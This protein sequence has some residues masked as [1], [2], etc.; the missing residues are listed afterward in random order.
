MSVKEELKKIPAKYRPLAQLLVAA[1][2]ELGLPRECEKKGKIQRPSLEERERMYKRR[3]IFV[4][5]Y[6]CTIRDWA[7]DKYSRDVAKRIINEIDVTFDTAG[8]FW[9]DKH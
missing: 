9:N 3:L 4:R 1:L 5:E 7:G 8:T 2:A 6:S